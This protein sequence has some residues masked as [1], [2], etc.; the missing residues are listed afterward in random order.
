MTM[1]KFPRIQKGSTTMFASVA[2]LMLVSMVTV[3]NANVSIMETKTS[4][5]E[6][7]TLQALLSAQ[8]GIDYVLANY[9]K[10]DLADLAEMELKVPNGDNLVTA[11]FYTITVDKTDINKPIITSN[12]LSADRS[13]KKELVQQFIFSSALRNDSSN[14]IAAPVITSNNANIDHT[15]LTQGT[16]PARV[17]SGGVI[18]GDKIPSQLSGNNADDYELRLLGSKLFQNDPLAESPMSKL[19]TVQMRSDDYLGLKHQSNYMECTPRCTNPS[20]L[21]TDSAYAKLHYI[22]GKL[23]LNNVTVGSSAF[24]VILVIDI[25]NDDDLV[26][27][28]S[29]IYGLVIVMDT[30]DSNDNDTTINGSII[31]D[32]NL[33]QGNDLTVNYDLTVFNNLS[34]VGTYTRI[35]G[36][37][38]DG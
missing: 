34:T 1:K 16:A 26:L 8:A 18:T 31:V 3:M 20:E 11:G 30:W 2:T 32:G 25:N 6:Y 23:T 33:L 37:W 15:R 14:Y 19:F 5:N 13:A 29:T 38:T 35:P 10:N 22:D 36:S 27:R 24:P 21:T 9:G 12:G 4:A 7:R 28:N 17:W